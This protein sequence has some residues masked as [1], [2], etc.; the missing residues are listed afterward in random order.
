MNSQTRLFN[1]INFQVHSNR[2][3][4]RFTRARGGLDQQLAQLRFVF[5]KAFE[6]GLYG[7]TVEAL[8]T[9]AAV[10]ESNQQPGARKAPRTH[11]TGNR[12]L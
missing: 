4:S 12:G 10:H 8:R 9:P 7:S 1:L 11:V 5:D 6:L 3:Q 2:K